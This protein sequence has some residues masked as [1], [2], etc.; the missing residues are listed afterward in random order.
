MPVSKPNAIPQWIA[1][2][3]LKLI[4]KDHVPSYEESDIA[5]WEQLREI[6]AEDDKPSLEGGVEADREDPLEDA[7]PQEVLRYEDTQD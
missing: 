4:I 6:Q 1:K 7:P 3:R 5:H 2:K